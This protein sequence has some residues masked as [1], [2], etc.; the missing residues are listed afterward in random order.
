MCGI[1]GL[2]KLKGNLNRKLAKELSKKLLLNLEERGSDATGMA[3]LNM[4]KDIYRFS[5][6]KNGMNAKSFIKT[7]SFQNL[8]D[9]EF[10]VVLLHTRAATH[11]SEKDN[12]NNHPHFNKKTQNIL[13][14]NGMIENDD[15]LKDKFKL[16]LDGVCDSEIILKLIDKLSFDKA[17]KEI[18]G[19]L[20]IAYTNEKDRTLTLYRNDESPLIIAYDIKEDIFIFASTEEM[21]GNL[22]LIE[23]EITCGDLKLIK[24]ADD[25]YYKELD[26]FQK[27]VF[28]FKNKKIQSKYIKN[29]SQFYFIDTKE[30]IFNNP[31][32]EQ[33][34]NF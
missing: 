20:A 31:S 8:F 22:C 34:M 17:I 11:G 12:T 5:I 2:I 21:F 10:N 32:K 3:L 33:H 14:H 27:I 29:K 25:F 23:K 7:K 18:I 19:N 9:K 6:L 28:N 4:S 26:N 16:E 1:G 13:I 15:K 30:F 24:Q